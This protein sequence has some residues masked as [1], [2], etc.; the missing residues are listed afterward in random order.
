[1][2]YRELEDVYEFHRN[3]RKTPW[4]SLFPHW[5]DEKDALLNAIG[6]EVERIKALSVF[7]LL[8]AGIKPPVL[9]WQESI[10]HKEYNA[11]F[12]AESLP[13]TIEIQAPLYKTWGSIILT[14]NTEKDIDGLILKLDNNNGFAINQLIAQEDI[15]E[16]NLTDNKVILN[17]KEI[18]PQKIGEGM[19]Y[20]IT[21]QNRQNYTEDYPLH[22]EVIRLQIFTNDT[23][24]TKCD[25]DIDVNLLNVVFTNEQNIEI[26]GLESVPIDRVELYAK[27]DFDYNSQY[28]GWHK[29]YE[30][31]YESNTNVVYDMITTHFYTKEFYVDVYFKTLQYPYQVG[32]PCYRDAETKSAYHVNNRLDMWGEQLGLE[33]RLYK[34]EIAEDEYYRTYPIYY[35]FDI[36]QDY[37]YYKRLISEYSW[38]ENPINDVDIKDTDGNNIIR[39][40]SINPFTEDF[41][42]HAKSHYPVD[43]EFINHNS[44]KPVAV[45]QQTTENVGIQTYFNDII[46]LLS[47]DDKKT[48]ITLNNYTDNNDVIYKRNKA[49]DKGEI[50]TNDYTQSVKYIASATHQSTE[51]LT[52]FDLSDLPQDVNIEDITVTVEAEST[53]NKKNKY[54]TETTGIL[55]PDYSDSE[56][57]F[58]P[59]TADKDYQLSKQEINYSNE[60]ISDYLNNIQIADE[61]I[62][63]DFIIGQFEGKI[64]DFVKIPFELYE[65]SEK[66][67]DITNVWL[68]YNG[69][70]RQA[71]YKEIDGE[72][73]IYAYVPNLSI[74][75]NIT[76]ICK[77]RTH[78]PFTHN[79]KVNKLNRY[80]EDG[81]T[82]EYQYING[83]INEDDEIQDISDYVEWHTDNIRN[84]LQKQGVYFRNVLKNI[85]TQSSTTIYIYNVTMRVT[86]SPKKSNFKMTTYINKKSDFPN[87]GSL[88]VNIENIGEKN[89][90]SHIDI[91]TPSNIQMEYN[92]IPVDLKVGAS[93]EREIDITASYPIDDGFY[94]I[95]TICEDEIKRD[96]IEVFS[97]GLIETGVSIL[98]HHGRYNDVLTLKAEVTAFDGATIDSTDSLVQFYING[99]AVGNKV[100]VHNNKAETSISPKDYYFTGTGSLTLEAKFLG[101]TKYASSSKK[102]TIFISKDDTRITLMANKIAP[103]KGPFELRAKVEY[104]N[105][106]TYVPVDKGTVE[107]YID[108]EILSSNTNLVQGVFIASIQ[109]IEN[110]P[111]EYTLYARY[112]G[113]ESYSGAETSQE[114]EIIGGET[115][116]SVFDIKAKPKTNINLKAK[117]VDINNKNIISG[118]IDFSI[119]DSDDNYITID[120]EK[121]KNIEVK[122]GIAISGD[123][124]LDIDIASDLNVKRYVIEAK[125]HNL[126]NEDTSEEFELYQQGKGL[127]YIYISKSDVKLEYPSVFYGTQYEPLGFYIKIIDNE[128]GSPVTY[129]KI[130]ITLENEN[131]SIEGT[132]DENG[133]VRL[134][135]KPL[136]F[137]AKDWNE[138]EKF[139]F[140]VH[141]DDLF[142]TYNDDDLNAN[143]DFF[144]NEED[145]TLHFIQGKQNVN[146][147]EVSFVYDPN[148]QKYNVVDTLSNELINDY[149]NEH[150]YITNGHLYART[151]K[152]VLRQYNIGAQNVKIEYVS[153]GQYKNKTEYLD[154]GLVINESNV[155]L[156]IHLYD[157]EY[158]DNDIITCYVTKYSLTDGVTTTNI[159][160]GK[161]QFIVDNYIL[162]TVEVANGRAI[163]NN[164]LLTNISAGEHLMNVK[165][166]GE[167]LTHS[168][169]TLKLSKIDPVIN[170]F[171]DQEIANKNS[172]IVV[173]LSTLENLN[174][175]LNGLISLYLDDELVGTQYLNGNEMLPGIV[176]EYNI[177]Q[178]KEEMQHYTDAERNIYIPGVIFNLLMPYDID[179]PNKHKIKVVYEGNG[180]LM[181]KTQE[182]NLL[183]TP[184]NIDINVKDN[185][186]VAQNEPCFLDATIT[187]KDDIINEGQLTLKYGDEV[188]ANTNVLDNKARL[189]WTPTTINQLNNYTI[190][191]TGSS[192]YNDKTIA[193]TINTINALNEITI[194]N[195]QQTTIEE[196]LMCLKP[197]G[198]IYI[199]EDITL[200]KSINITK[201][202]SIIGENGV[203]IIKDVEELSINNIPTVSINDVQNMHKINKLSTEHLNATDFKL[204]DNQ[205]Y[206]K[207]KTEMLPIFL[208]ES[209]AFYCEVPL[210]IDNVLS[211]LNIIIDKDVEVDF[212][213]LT[214]KSNDAQSLNNFAIYNEG[215]CLITYSIIESTAK[216]YN[217][218]TLTAHRNLIYGLCQG[219]SDLDN[220]WWG[221]NTPPY[222][223]NNHIIIDVNT[224]NTPAVIS[225]EVDVVGELIGANGQHYHIPQVQY[226]FNADSGYFSTDIGKTTNEKAH[227]T[228]LDAI[229]EGNIYFTVDNE[230]V[231]CPVYDYERKTE[232][233]IDDVKEVLLNYQMPITAKIQSCADTYYEFND[234]NNI[235]KSTQPINEG[236]VDFFI[237]D[238]IN[239]NSE[240]QQIGHQSVSNGEAKIQV[241]FKD[242]IYD[243]N[244][245]YKITAKYFGQENFFDSTNT[246]IIT[247]INENNVCFVSNEGND[248]NDGAYSSPVA[249]ISKA[250]TLNKDKIF[251]LEGEYTAENIVITHNVSIQKYNGTVSFRN[252]TGNILFDIPKNNRLYIS[253]IDFIENDMNYIFNNSG[254]LVVEE[255]IFYNNKG[256]LFKNNLTSTLFSV[257][258]CAIV[259]NDNIEDNINTSKYSYCWFGDNN[260]ENFDNYIVM[261]TKQSKD[262]LYIGSLAHV[263]AE[264]NNYMHNNIMYQLDKPLP[265]RIARFAS[266]VGEVKPIQDYT[267]ANQSTSLV[268]TLKHNNTYQYIIN[269]KN[270]QFYDKQKIKL[271][272][273]IADV[274]GDL[275]TSNNERLRIQ[276]QGYNVDIDT[277]QSIKNGQVIYELSSLPLGDYSLIC[278]YNKGGQVYTLHT[279]FNVKPLDIQL[280][281]T[282]DNYSHLYYTELTGT[283]QDNVGANID[284]ELLNIKINN[285]NNETLVEDTL[286][287]TDGIINKK[288]SYDLLSP[289]QYTLILDN[290]GIRTN[291]DVLLYE[292]P[293]S[294]KSQKTKIDFDYNTIEKDVNNILI[295][296]INDAEGKE[297]QSGKVTIELDNNIYKENIEVNNGI[298]IIDNFYVHESGQHSI[299]IYYKDSM[300]YYEDSVYINSKFGVG[301]YNV[302]FSISETDIITADIGKDLIL[303]FNVTDIGNQNINTGYINLY[304][305]DKIF[306][307]Y[308]SPINGLISYTAP[309]PDGICAGM[310]RFTIEYIDN[311]GK[312]LDTILNTYL[313]ISQIDTEISVTTVSGQSGL[314]TTV[315]YRI[316]SIYG[317]V[318]NGILTAFFK[319]G[320][321][322]QQIGK[323]IV[324]D[325]I[326]NQITFTTPFLP[327]NNNYEIIFRYHDNNNNY[328]DSEVTTK[329]IIEKSKVVIEPQKTWYYPQKDFEF[330]VDVRNKDN[331]IIDEG[332]I[333]LYINNVKEH[334]DILVVNG[335]A[336]IPLFFNK[337]SVFNL[338]IVYKEDDYYSQT[339][340]PLEFNVDSIPIDNITFNDALTSL[341]NR[342]FSTKLIFETLDN[343]NVKDGI[344][345]ILF[346]NNIVGSYY[347]AENNKYVDFN[348]GD[349][350]KGEHTLTL[351]YYNSSLFDDYTHDYTFTIES[352]TIDIRINI[353][354]NHESQDIKAI[355]SDTISLQTSFGIIND[356]TWDWQQ[357]S[358]IVNYYIGIPQ[359][360]MN[361]LGETYIYDYYYKFIGLQEFENTSSETYEYILTNDLLEYAVDRLETH[362]SIKAHFLGNDEYDEA[363]E[364]I[365]LNIYKQTTKITMPENLQFEY[366]S[367]IN[368][369][370]NITNSDNE[371]L[372]GKN[373]I[374]MYIN[375]ELIATCTTIDGEGTF[376]Y[377]LNNKYTI[378][379][380][381]LRAVFNG[382]AINKASESSINFA[383]TPFTPTL[384]TEEIDMYV[385]GENILD[386]IIYDKNGVII[387]EG[388]LQYYINDEFQFECHPNIPQGVWFS[389]EYREDWNLTVKYTSNNLRK[390]NNF[391]KTI[392]VHMVKNPIELSI[393]APEKIY[394]GVPFDITLKADA[395]TTHLPVDLNFKKG[396][397][398]YVMLNGSVTTSLTYPITLED[399]ATIEDYITTD[400]N[401]IFEAN[402]ILLKLRIKNQN[403][404]T[405]DTT[406]PESAT[407]VHTLQKAIDLVSDYG[408]IQ[409]NTPLSNQTIYLNKNLTIKGNAELTNCVINNESNKLTIDGLIFKNGTQTSI[410]NSG[411]LNIN[412]CTFR[413][414]QDTA[415]ESNGYIYISKTKFENNTAEK[416]ACIKIGSNN[417]K[418]SIKECQ[419]TNNH[420]T[421]YGG[422]IYS[423]KVNDMEILDNEFAH[424]NKAD[425]GGSSIYAYGNITISSNTFFDNQGVS[426][427][428]LLRG[429]TSL[430]NNLFDGK[431]KS[432]QLSG[433]VD[434][435]A[436]LN[437]W[438]FNELSDIYSH[439]DITSIDNYLIA[440]YEII[441]KEDGKRI[442]GR[443]NKYINRLESEITTINILDKRF[444]IKIDNVVYYINEEIPITMASNVII[445]QDIIY[446]ERGF[447]ANEIDNLL[448]DYADID[449]THSQYEDE[450]NNLSN[451]LGR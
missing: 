153:E 111:G 138:L 188:I 45:S 145:G 270:K 143:F 447:N 372:I 79:I 358:G 13:K 271:E 393:Y 284:N 36:E 114:F 272:L 281:V 382:S 121:V 336:I 368:I 52:Y 367:E 451:R 392:R 298:A 151:T 354:E 125:Y 379:T 101:T 6:D 230:T 301:I 252:N 221:S 87:I 192:N 363:I 82:V 347:V 164:K 61:N 236:Y 86:Y 59:L 444:P 28:N 34:T 439:N 43:K 132:P 280:D 97:D 199:T 357:I 424:N 351:K 405:L 327:A 112:S 165:Y 352:K 333:D 326:V 305:D 335:Q 94:D 406:Q 14:N 277:Y 141:D 396:T 437:Y 66:V 256:T 37:W 179:V 214:F 329:L 15:L 366:Q 344:I 427:I 390:Y 144:Y 359:Y 154:D 185:I 259:N 225:E 445:G 102:S 172:N 369:N 325:N 395:P 158:T 100:Q 119:K 74:I 38:Y 253:N 266:D 108:D 260:P 129:G 127:G 77:S 246:T 23:E 16:I 237:N 191:Y 190:T 290:N 171:I 295:V 324:T 80:S 331:S 431:I 251:L 238:D 31:E 7:S 65:N 25:I 348:I 40:Y 249:T 282:V 92:S 275:I 12:H 228:F 2:D 404:I 55:I 120:N 187:Y 11:H 182:R 311:D 178:L 224:V 21:Q 449:H 30:K 274:Y 46:N 150:I 234:N 209:G 181:P 373:N 3:M 216:L 233:I 356:D 60:D 255:C 443:I 207:T 195:S 128:V 29:V 313:N 243:A 117:V 342:L 294:V 99:F 349:E 376:K 95:V 402:Q 48:S 72:E 385:G 81:A 212:N 161:V 155:D 387:E 148:T 386:N 109:Q 205:I 84:L 123:I 70:I 258:L 309:L 350:P 432:V 42:I 62:V 35:P 222:K 232:V 204:I 315:K 91:V 296:E 5:Y 226:T 223:V 436:D 291:Y 276:I 89:F 44:F 418:T 278:T 22:N 411:I 398:T 420:A 269:L 163:L 337:A 58:I 152:D 429:M 162:D 430:E 321:D 399:N 417:Y 401:D 383:I 262:I 293:L 33:R 273:S 403:N 126:L 314:K 318:N 323:S 215:K 169:T 41:V 328:K 137:T 435:D 18:E 297:V 245:E 241:F 412:N 175:P 85:D 413:N 374:D 4:L 142:R 133:I 208:T 244:K 428:Y 312:Y 167:S 279:T 446:I 103:Y 248:N 166:V 306:A 397:D 1:M 83:P 210:N 375:D 239:D 288:I 434:I 57:F 343:Y 213:N 346:D 78:K 391:T 381:T 302:L 217:K 378:D 39:L 160:N 450:L 32:F 353:D 24:A 448:D 20:F 330:V 19:P 303:N 400:G 257:S 159:N 115:K 292:M 389:S 198:T 264:L 361:D 304:I 422:C 157:L 113:T 93:L 201:D 71:S 370:V 73:C 334:E 261:T 283:A 27:Y 355:S 287:I 242:N 147:D 96:S 106:E 362:Y 9:L 240:G 229:K 423:D 124:F 203:S 332:Y 289:G 438:G 425:V 69:N 186:Y 8:N 380:Y 433:N 10:D 47:D 263:T 140:N 200:K 104:Y 345:D 189:S 211:D 67:D 130:R 320:N 340:Y 415:I 75:N 88:V 135:Y 388:I 407:N 414:N 139:S 408:S 53:D 50:K 319:N 220:N 254:S 426:E 196:A 68:Y 146:N 231:S 365:D 219:D 384:K 51:L 268:N 360:R 170:I 17:N 409:I 316:D 134:I 364:Y 54:S 421:L 194:P 394:R 202:C 105:G 308:I 193:I 310:H 286:L 419:F 317:N 322:E 131:V 173:T 377:R 197:K 76:I 174:V 299:V 416:G 90:S 218:G 267:Y 183:Q 136:D 440:D 441:E 177:E 265:L 184:V 176:D 110:P 168:Y 156:D 206:I 122:N 180:Y 118:Y 49:Y 64:G 250:L 442:I 26:T 371:R 235:I 98:P 107:F 149:D 410:Y 63:Q 247:T 285:Q 338:D 300:H 116:V 56:R 227:T 307:P 339:H 341:P